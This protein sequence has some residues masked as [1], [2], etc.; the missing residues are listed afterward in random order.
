MI[1]KKFFNIRVLIIKPSFFLGLSICLHLLLLSLTIV[2]SSSFFKRLFLNQSAKISG[3]STQIKVDIIALPTE[4]AFKKTFFESEKGGKDISKK[5]KQ[6]AKPQI[7][8]DLSKKKVPKKKNLD[9]SSLDKYVEGVK[10]EHLRRGNIKQEGGRLST[11]GATNEEA[12]WYDSYV[13]DLIEQNL[14]IPV[15][16]KETQ[17]TAIFRLVLH[18]DGSVKEVELLESSGNREFD[19]YASQAVWDSSPFEKPPDDIADE[20][21][22]RGRVIGLHPSSDL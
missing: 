7:A 18:G 21:Y 5:S 20:Y 8:L 6:K 2:T 22:K 13:E 3:R 1:K 14:K 15:Y 9:S 12:H 19:E 11:S 10:K 16:L 17:G 4:L